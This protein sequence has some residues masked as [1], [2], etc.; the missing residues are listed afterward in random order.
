MSDVLNPERLR[1]IATELA[2][3]SR[4]EISLDKLGELALH[5]IVAREEAQRI[6]DG[7]YPEEQR[8]RAKEELKHL[9]E[10]EKNVVHLYMLS[11]FRPKE[12]TERIK[13][14]YPMWKPP[15]VS[16]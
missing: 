1:Y 15:E 5:I 6:L 2:E 8:R 7:D 10:L 12:W 9:K 16:Y 11:I 13:A 14:K 4:E 3:A